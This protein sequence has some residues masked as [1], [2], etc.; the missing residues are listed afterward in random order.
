MPQRI[1]VGPRQNRDLINRN[2]ADPNLANRN[3]RCP[4]IA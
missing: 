3:L 2:L 1:G 4:D